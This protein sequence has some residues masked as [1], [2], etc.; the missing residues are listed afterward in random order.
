MPTPYQVYHGATADGEDTDSDDNL[1]RP[2]S[3]C[4]AIATSGVPPRCGG[5]GGNCHWEV[6][7]STIPP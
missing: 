6:I 1:H 4:T 3:H 2:G 7:L 5:L